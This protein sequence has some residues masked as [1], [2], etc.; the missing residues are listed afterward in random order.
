MSNL[1]VACERAKT[2][3]ARTASE[4]RTGKG[5]QVFINNMIV[6]I[7]LLKIKKIQKLQKN[8]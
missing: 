4:T 3:S 7:L 5:A 6:F 2:I 1:E 8:A